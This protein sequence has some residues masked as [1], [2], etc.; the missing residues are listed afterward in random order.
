MNIQIRWQ[1]LKTLE[2]RNILATILL[3]V[4]VM[5]TNGQE[6]KNYDLE[7]DF[8]IPK[9]II[10][11]SG[12]VNIDFQDQDSIILVLWKNS[13][14]EEIL[15]DGERAVYSFDTIGKSPNYYIPNGGKLII[16]NTK[17]E[18]IKTCIFSYSCDMSNVGGWAKSFSEDWIELGF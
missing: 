18:N 4:F 10:K 2:M 11:V 1:A 6:I 5:A 14:I 9:R 8:N 13:N 7:V 16:K 15:V 17:G 3:S 12:K